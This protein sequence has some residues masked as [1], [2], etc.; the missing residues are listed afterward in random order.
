MAAVTCA[1][2]GS[3]ESPAVEIGATRSSRRTA[4]TTS[5]R[6]RGGTPRVTICFIHTLNSKQLI[7]ICNEPG[8]EIFRIARRL[9]A[10]F[11]KAYKSGR[12]HGEILDAWRSGAPRRKLASRRHGYETQFDDLE[13]ATPALAA[14]NEKLDLMEQRS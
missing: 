8:L 10:P 14:L 4:S 1:D 3:R 12:L 11:I 9:D 2:G 13:G 7:S 5:R 6:E